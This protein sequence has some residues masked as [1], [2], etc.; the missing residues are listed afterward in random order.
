MVKNPPA[1]AGDTGSI[2]GPGRFHIPCFG[3]TKPVSQLLN[4]HSRVRKLQ[5]EKL[6]YHNYRKPACSN[7]DPVQ[8]K[9][10]RERERERDIRCIKT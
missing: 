10:K 1:S 2:P 7:E 6:K 5:Q 9:K 3:A 8:S 4:L